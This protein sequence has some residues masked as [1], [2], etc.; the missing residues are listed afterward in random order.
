MFFCG[1]VAQGNTRAGKAPWGKSRVEDAQGGRPKSAEGKKAPEKPPGAKAAGKTATRKR[2]AKKHTY[3][4]AESNKKKHLEV[5]RSLAF[6]RALATERFGNRTKSPLG[7]KG[8]GQGRLEARGEVLLGRGGRIF[9]SEYGR[10][11]VIRSLRALW[12]GCIVRSLWTAACF[13]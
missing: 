2:A 7:Q 6:L 9:F 3:R 11:V 10:A 12:R 8:G 13:G 4:L 5:L 1:E